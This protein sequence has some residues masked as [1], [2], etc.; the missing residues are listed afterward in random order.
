[1]LD[2]LGNRIIEMR[3]SKNLSQ[4]ELARRIDKS[5]DVLGR[6]ERGTV[7]ASIEVVVKIARVLEVPLDYLVGNANTYLSR[8]T[9]ERLEKI[10]DMPK[11]EQQILYRVIDSFIRD[12]NV[13]KTYK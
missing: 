4:T 9:L 7:S 5:K 6:Y 12:Y 2:I 1:M 11:E 13:R 8:E 10:E 3:K